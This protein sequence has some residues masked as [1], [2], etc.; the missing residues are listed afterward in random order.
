M[1]SRRSAPSLSIST[2]YDRYVSAYPRGLDSH[3][4]DGMETS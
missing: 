3:S 1:I 2:I 4:A